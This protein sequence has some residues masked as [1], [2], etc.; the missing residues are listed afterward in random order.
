MSLSCSF[1]DLPVLN[2]EIIRFR[3][4]GGFF[5]SIHLLPSIPHSVALQVTHS[6]KQT[7]VGPRLNH[8]MS[9]VIQGARMNM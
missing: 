2:C 3:F 9:N 7:A 5:S 6:A 8:R 4:V 1:H